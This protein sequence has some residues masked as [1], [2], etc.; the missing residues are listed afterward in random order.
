MADETGKFNLKCDQ[1]I[2]VQELWLMNF[3]NLINNKKKLAINGLSQPYG[4]KSF[5]NVP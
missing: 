5:L 3:L 1:K 4:L 2:C